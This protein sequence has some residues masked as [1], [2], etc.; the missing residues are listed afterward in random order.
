MAPVTPPLPAHSA[1]AARLA[2]SGALLGLALASLCLYRQAALT[3]DLRKD[4]PTF[5]ALFGALFVLY[6]VAVV[7]ILQYE[8]R[9]GPAAPW[10][11]LALIILSGM[12]MRA[13][14][15]PMRPTL[16]DDMYRY[17]WDGRVQ[18]AGFSPYQFAPADAHLAHL[19]RS[20]LTIWPFI[21][22]KTAVTIYPPGAQL[23]FLAIYRLHPDSVVWTK[24]ALT[25]AEV[26]AWALLAWWL[27]RRRLSLLRLLILAWS[28]LAIFEIAGHGHL[29]ALMLAPLI[30]AFLASEMRRPVWVG[31][32]LAL[33]V[34]LK[35]F[36]AL[37]FPALWT[38]RD[39]TK[40]SLAFLGVITVGYA[41]Y[42]GRGGSVLGF[43][44]NYLTERFNVGPAALLVNGIGRLAPAVD[45]PWRLAQALQGGALLLLLAAFV[46]RPSHTPA[47][48]QRR[49]WT[50]MAI[51][52]IFSQNLFSWYLLWA[53]PLLA[54][55][56]RP[57]RAGLRADA[58]TGWLLFSGLVALSYTFFIAW[59][60]APWA[61]WTQYGALIAFLS[62]DLLRRL[63]WFRPCRAPA[64]G[65]P[66]AWET[67]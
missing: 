46:W 45:D 42:W 61:I 36:P 29:D 64:G 15:L 18:A 55:D 26:G 53:L 48:T 58:A 9:H 39:S 49:V 59:K 12:A 14:L 54:L 24:T 67:P 50:I 31:V 34:L 51:F 6:L 22:R 16:S 63:R 38:R 10:P 41:F 21:N 44:P 66:G 13:L 40:A 17:I 25:L 27:R 52:I 4:V 43:L 32:S 33:A 3:P 1:R 47:Q 11:W 8:H 2:M 30:A 20:D 56:V 23:A 62:A 37:L 60:P 28:P 65:R 5:L 7:S 57:G 19:R 35:L